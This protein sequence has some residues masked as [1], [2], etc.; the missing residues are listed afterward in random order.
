MSPA[1]IYAAWQRVRAETGANTIA[2]FRELCRQNPD[3]ARALFRLAAEERGKG[4]VA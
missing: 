1:E 4:G 3:H 2:G